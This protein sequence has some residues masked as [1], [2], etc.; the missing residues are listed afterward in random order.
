MS[1]LPRT[2]PNNEPAAFNIARATAE[3][4]L[5]VEEVRY[6]VWRTA[7]PAVAPD[8][9]SVEDV[10]EI[11]ADQTE[12]IAQGRNALKDPLRNIYVVKDE[13]KVVGFSIA[14]KDSEH[15]GRLRSIYLLE[16]FQGKGIGKELLRETLEWLEPEK[17]DIRLEVVETNQHAISLYSK[18][19]FVVA[20]K[21]PPEIPE[22]PLKYIPHLEMIRE[23]GVMS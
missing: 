1:E 2:T 14:V 17:R 15:E 10:D 18:F 16:E 7:Y 19:G 6:K 21:F 12:A 11:F 22:P 23:A 4:I 20:R 3:D 8:Y 5:M 9:I 13:D